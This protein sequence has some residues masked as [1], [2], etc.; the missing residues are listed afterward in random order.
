MTESVGV[1]PGD[2]PGRRQLGRQELSETTQH[3]LLR[4]QDVDSPVRQ[5][6]QTGMALNND[7][8][9]AHKLHMT[10]QEDTMDQAGLDPTGN[11]TVSQDKVSDVQR[12]TAIGSDQY[13]PSYDMNTDLGNAN[14]ENSNHN[15]SCNNSP[16]SNGANESGFVDQS[17][18]RSGSTSSYL[19]AGGIEGRRID[20]GY[21][22]VGGA[23]Q[24]LKSAEEEPRA[25]IARITEI[26][27]TPEKGSEA[28]TPEFIFATFPAPSGVHT[29]DSPK[30]SRV[31]QNELSASK[32]PKPDQLNLAEVNKASPE[33]TR[34]RGLVSSHDSLSPRRL[35]PR[36]VRRKHTVSGVTE[37]ARA[38][39][40]QL[41]RRSYSQNDASPRS[42]LQNEYVGI[43]EMT[44]IEEQPNQ[45]TKEQDYSRRPPR[46]PRSPLNRN[47]SYSA[48]VGG[49]PLKSDSFDFTCDDDDLTSHSP[50]SKTNS[51]ISGSSRSS[52]F[53]HRFAVRPL[54]TED[55][56]AALQGKHRKKTKLRRRPHR[57]STGSSSS[58]SDSDA[59]D[60]K[61][62]ARRKKSFLKRAS[63]RLRQSFRIKRDHSR[64]FDDFSDTERDKIQSK[65]RKPK[66]K[67]VSS[68]SQSFEARGEV[69]HTHVHRHIH[70]EENKVNNG[71][72]I[73]LRTEDIDVVQDSKDDRH[74]EVKL[75]TKESWPKDKEKKSVW[76][77]IIKKIRKGS[78]KLQRRSS[79]KGKKN[80]FLR[81]SK[82]LMLSKNPF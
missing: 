80:C 14:L 12:N 24:L 18:T 30:E 2:P 23:D 59:F 25:P 79:S 39:L 4:G 22:S 43:S 1:Q 51:I 66:K 65:K 31:G 45:P 29:S 15:D 46:S 68:P 50:V 53:K 48:A 74:V 49:P 77:N 40:E 67:T 47:K 17:S 75:R 16:F 69:I 71:T 3:Y 60:P 7:K 61:S 73:V 35:R 56:E 52:S 26:S 6:H 81:Q 64:D 62:G 27:L 58:A 9:C 8:R 42:T 41:L 5:S 13:T 55:V 28:A 72:V 44:V 34:G 63:E 76:D 10:F 20:S 19:M 82:I 21:H 57:D 11:D 78:H 37:E 54:H 38:V 33:P 36:T 70:Q 32:K